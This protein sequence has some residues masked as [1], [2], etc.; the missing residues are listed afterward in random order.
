[1]LCDFV[2]FDDLT[3]RIFMGN[4]ILLTLYLFV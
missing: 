4:V 3:F 2:V 1:M